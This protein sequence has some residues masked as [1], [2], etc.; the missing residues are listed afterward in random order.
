VG[1]DAVVVTSIV[2]V[3]PALMG[4]DETAKA[5]VPEEKMLRVRDARRLADVRTVAE[6][7]EGDVE[8]V[9]DLAAKVVK[10]RLMA[11]ASK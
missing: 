2:D 10:E 7:A 8:P 3:V 6:G 9:L 1:A 11:P 4:L 5:K